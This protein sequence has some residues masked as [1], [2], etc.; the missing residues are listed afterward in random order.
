VLVAM[1]RSVGQRQTTA[2]RHDQSN[3]PGHAVSAEF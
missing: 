3:G 2:D 1:L